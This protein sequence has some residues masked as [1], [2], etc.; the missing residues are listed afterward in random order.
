MQ[1]VNI[2]ETLLKIFLNK[3]ME[4]TLEHLDRKGLEEIYAEIDRL[5][6][7]KIE[8]TA[9]KRYQDFFHIFIMIGLALVLGWWILKQTYFSLFKVVR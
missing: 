5:E 4:S 1:N 7:T 2:D 9:F 8:I 3:P 6:K